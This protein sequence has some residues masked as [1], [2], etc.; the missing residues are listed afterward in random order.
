MLSQAKA[1][2]SDASALPHSVFLVTELWPGTTRH[3]WDM[4][5][6]KLRASAFKMHPWALLLHLFYSPQ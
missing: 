1:M 6:I 5:G 2:G 3:T 4:L